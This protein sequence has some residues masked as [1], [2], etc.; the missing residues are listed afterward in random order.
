MVI[1]KTL[2]LV[3]IFTSTNLFSIQYKIV[4]QKQITADF[5]N[6]ID[7]SIGQ[8]IFQWITGKEPV[9][10]DRPFSLCKDTRDNLVVLDQGSGSLLTFSPEQGFQKID[11]NSFTFPSGTMVSPSGF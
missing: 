9:K 6:K 7:L 4:Y 3:F 11:Q 8:K 1:V 5:N 2:F 10:L